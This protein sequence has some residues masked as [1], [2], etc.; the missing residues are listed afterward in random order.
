ML[1]ESVVTCAIVM[2][3]WYLL[4]Q[5]AVQAIVL[6][7]Q[8]EQ[9]IQGLS[10][11]STTIEKLRSGAY[12]LKDQVITQD[13]LTVTVACTQKLCAGLLYNVTITVTQNTQEVL[14][15]QTALLRS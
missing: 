12:Q 4:V 8:I 9:K 14:C 1:L 3:T 7:Q 2:I 5:C 10:L 11:A 13:A 15:I 6:E